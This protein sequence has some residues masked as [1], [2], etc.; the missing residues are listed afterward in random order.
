MSRMKTFNDAV[1]S[2]IPHTNTISRPHTKGSQA[3]Y[4]FGLPPDTNTNTNSSPI[5]ISR[6]R[7]FDRTAA[8]GMTSRGTATRL[9]NPALSTSEVVPDSQ[10]MVKKLNGTSPHSTNTAKFGIDPLAKTLVK[11][12]VITP[13]ITSG[14]NSDQKTPSDMLR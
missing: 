7:Q 2:E 6:C 5:W 11:T 1:I 3:Q 14:F 8:S 10:A 4:R 12:N 13:I 9:I